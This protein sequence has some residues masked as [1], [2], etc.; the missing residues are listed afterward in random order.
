MVLELTQGREATAAGYAEFVSLE[1][2]YA[3]GMGIMLASGQLSLPRHNVET[4]KNFISWMALSYDR[5]RSLP[6]VFRGAGAF[7][8]KLEVFNPCNSKA[9]QAHLKEVLEECVY[10][11]ATFRGLTPTQKA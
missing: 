7:L 1:E 4:M 9:V 10:D 11:G 6:S 8:S 2:K 5:A 3:M